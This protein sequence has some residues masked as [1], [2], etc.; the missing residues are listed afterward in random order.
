M[1][2]PD[3]LTILLACVV[4]VEPFLVLYAAPRITRRLTEANA[5]RLFRE[6][7]GLDPDGEDTLLDATR[8]VLQGALV[9]LAVPSAEDQAAARAETAQA[10]ADAVAAA[11]A[12][13]VPAAV[14]AAVA[15]A[16]KGRMGAL[17]GA[18]AEARQ[19]K[20]SAEFAFKQAVANHP[21]GGLAAVMGLAMLKKADPE[22]YNLA[23]EAVALKPD[24]V[25]EFLDKH[26]SKLR[27]GFGG[28]DTARPATSRVLRA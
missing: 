23:V 24:S 17:S 12:Q 13:A 2:A 11:A 6:L 15:E 21:K 8:A 4:I 20:A 9:P 1:A 7:A 18:A 3:P 19:S 28:G 10:I 14:E 5:R 27:L 22:I 16:V 26:G 25:D